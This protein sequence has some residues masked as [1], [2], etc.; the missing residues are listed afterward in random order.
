M[1]PMG[2]RVRFLQEQ[3]YGSYGNNS[4]V[5][6]GTRVRSFGDNS[7]VPSETRDRDSFGNRV[8][9]PTGTKIMIL[10]RMILCPYRERDI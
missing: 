6:S 9:D 5:P 7:M 10:A 1:V 3:E 2:K 8:E 4:R